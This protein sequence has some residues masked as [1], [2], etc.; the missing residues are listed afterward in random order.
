MG[1]TNRRGTRKAARSRQVEA[2]VPQ[3]VEATTGRRIDAPPEAT[4]TARVPAPRKTGNDSPENG[5]IGARQETVALGKTLAR[6]SVALR[7]RAT[8][9]ERM[10]D[11]NSLV[12]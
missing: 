5:R 1:K 11:L 12:I 6:G 4:E 9:E 8:H 3:A 2:I 7:P 10:V